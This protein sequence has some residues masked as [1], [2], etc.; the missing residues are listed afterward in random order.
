[1]TTPSSHSEPSSLPIVVIGGGAAGYFAAIACAEANPKRLVIIL[2]Q[3]RAPLSKVKVSGGGRCNVTHACFDPKALTAFYPRGGKE[4]LGPFHAFQPRDTVA[5]FAGRG[6]ELK[7]END[8]RMFPV[9]DSSQTIIDALTAA[10]QQAGVTLRTGASVSTVVKNKAGTFRVTLDG[11]ETIPCEKLLL[12]TGSGRRG[13]EWAMS[14]GH[15]IETPVPS[16]FTFHVPDE[17]LK[18]LEGIAMPKAEVKLKGTKFKQTGPVL[19]TH[20]GLSG[21]AIIKLSAWGARFLHDAHYEAEL[22]INWIA[23][24]PDAVEQGLRDLKG[25]YPKRYVSSMPAFGTQRRLWERILQSVDIVPAQRWTDLNKEQM[26]A[27]TGALTAARFQTNGKSPFKEEFVTCGG[28]RLSEVNFKT[29]ES[30][31]CAG[32]Y[33][34]GEILDVDAVTGGF[35]FQN[36]WTTGFL[37]G[38][39]MAEA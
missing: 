7:T 27:I 23:W 11:G 9:T 6:V 4:L 33:L 34:A 5:W 35:N 15:K 39:A 18:G 25:E 20:V 8:G 36:A 13:F 28:I 12:A 32:L 3:G 19:I 16:L 37:A 30:R 10:A 14:L 31:A 26:S 29:M 21:P 17:R 38:R 2:E 22:I 24:E 1:M